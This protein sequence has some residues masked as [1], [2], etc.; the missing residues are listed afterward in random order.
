[1]A[2]DKDIREPLSEFLEEQYGRIRILEEKQMGRSRAEL[3]EKTLV[4]IRPLPDFLKLL[5][6]GISHFHTHR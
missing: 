6:A 2:Y 1:M 4:A 5:L 3:A